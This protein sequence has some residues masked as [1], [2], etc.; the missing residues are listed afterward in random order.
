MVNNINIE[1]NNNDNDQNSNNLN[2]KEGGAVN[3]TDLQEQQ[4]TS[5]MKAPGN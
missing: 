4:T 3:Q 5:M 2:N 1:I